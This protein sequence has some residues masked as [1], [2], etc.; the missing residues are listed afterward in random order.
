MSI[1]AKLN[2]FQPQVLSILRI[3]SGLFLLQHGLSKL[4]Q[5]PYVESLANVPLFSQL[6]IGGIIE[7]VG[8]ILLILG[9]FTRPAA[10]ILSGLTA[11][12]YFQFHLPRGFYPLTNGGELAALFS[13]VFLYIVFAGPG[14][15]SLD[16]KRA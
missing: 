15:W 11:V 14:A 16:G 3:A 8:S 9:L 6:G 4:I 10:F 7:T 5:F 1:A 12:A 13:F 2:S